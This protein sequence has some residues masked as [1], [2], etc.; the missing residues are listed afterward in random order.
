MADLTATA[1]ANAD[2]RYNS[3]VEA[4]KRRIQDIQAQRDANDAALQ[5]YGNTGRGVIGQVYDVLDQK[6][7]SNRVD[8]RNSMTSAIGQMSEGYDKAQRVGEGWRDSARQFAAEAGVQQPGYEDAYAYQQAK[9]EDVIGRVFGN[10]AERGA[11]AV[12]NQQAWASNIDSIYGMGQNI[13]SQMRADAGSRFESELLRALADN[14]LNAQ[15]DETDIYGNISSTLAER[16]NFITSEL[17]RLAESQWERSFKEAQLRQ[18]AEQANAE[19]SLRAA[20]MA[21]DR[22]YKQAAMN[23]ADTMSE[24]ERLDYE[25]RKRALM[26]DERQTERNMSAAEM[27]AEMARKRTITDYLMQDPTLNNEQR[28]AILRDQGWLPAAAPDSTQATTTTPAFNL[29][30]AA[31]QR[32]YGEDYLGKQGNSY[33]GTKNSS[34]LGRLFR[35]VRDRGFFQV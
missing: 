1:T 34:M 27:Q 8:N 4:L 14:R 32:L 10:I 17:A 12:G 21:D 7:A 35:T 9:L 6:L 26:N 2:L 24:K 30:R 25:L 3:Q 15:R 20:A 11:A 31:A 5:G 28:L 29:D 18:Q 22:A 23:K 19:L 13:G 16:G 33:D